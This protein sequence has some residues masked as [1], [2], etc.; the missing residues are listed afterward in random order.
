MDNKVAMVTGASRGIGRSIALALAKDGFDLVLNDIDR[1]ADALDEVAALIEAEGRRSLV[2]VA[3]VRDKA[4]IH[5]IVRTAAARMGRIDVLV[6]NAG[7]L[8]SA[9]IED[10]TEEQWDEVF[11]VNAKG[12][13]LV[14]QAVLP[15]MREQGYGRIV[16]I[17]S[18]GGKRGAP[19]QAHY[20]ASK[21]AVLEFTRVLAMELEDS[22]I[23]ANSVCPGII[24]T[25]LGKANLPDQASI[26][27]WAAATAQRRIGYPDD[28]AGAVCFL[29][30]NAAA[31]ITGQSLNVCGGLIF[32]GG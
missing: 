9:R 20:C 6:N 19:G 14:T 25:E 7:I 31:F 10:L 22:G 32:D 16:N 30:S 17:A 18:V 8:T 23:T 13:F 26:D 4:A 29:A 21:A 11:A 12:V 28:V 15:Y 3:D 1:Q 2:T 27:R 5:G 24:M